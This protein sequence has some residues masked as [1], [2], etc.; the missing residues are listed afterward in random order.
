MPDDVLAATWGWLSNPTGDSR[1]QFYSAEEGEE[2]PLP[3]KA[4]A[5][6][7]RAKSTPGGAMQ[8]GA[9]P[10]AKK[11]ATVTSLA[12]SMEAMAAHLPKLSAQ[13]QNL[14]ERTA[15]IEAGSPVRN[16]SQLPQSIGSCPTH[17]LWQAAPLSSFAKLMPPPPRSVPARPKPQSGTGVVQSQV[18]ESQVERPEEGSQLELA[19]AVLAQSEALTTLVSHISSGETWGQIQRL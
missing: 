11:R 12:E 4:P 7:A 16:Q 2:Q 3:V 10:K 1:I 17:G 19:R 18:G 14:A 6:K 15:A 5:G 8:P 13:V 9:V